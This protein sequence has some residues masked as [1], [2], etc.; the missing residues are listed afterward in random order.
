MEKMA[1]SNRADSNRDHSRNSRA[2]SIRGHNRNSRAD[3][4]DDSS[5][6]DGDSNGGST[7]S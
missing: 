6:R 7:L 2:D 5:S 3:N 1:D 4:N